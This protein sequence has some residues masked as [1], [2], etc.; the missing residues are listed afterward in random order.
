M[1]DA[2]RESPGA[3]R[4]AWQREAERRSA[5]AGGALSHEDA[6]LRALLEGSD[7]ALANA[8]RLRAAAALIDHDYLA[9]WVDELGLRERWRALG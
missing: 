3:R 6:V 7:A 1:S 4:S 5:R 9:Y 8:A 2:H